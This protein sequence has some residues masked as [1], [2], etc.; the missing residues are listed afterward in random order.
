MTAPTVRVVRRWVTMDG[1]AFRDVLVLEG[2]TP[3]VVYRVQRFVRQADGTALSVEDHQTLITADP[4]VDCLMNTTYNWTT[5]FKNDAA[6]GV[7]STLA[8][9]IS[10]E[11]KNTREGGD[12]TTLSNA[13]ISYVDNLSTYVGCNFNIVSGLFAI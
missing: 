10:S 11:S 13:K 4:L 7:F 3:D 6:G 2:N 5:N 9:Q 12:G 8:A 1:M